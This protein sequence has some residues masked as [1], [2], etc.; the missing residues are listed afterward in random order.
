MLDRRY[1]LTDVLRFKNYAYA[2]LPLFIGWL[3]V[4]VFPVILNE[5]RAYHQRLFS[6]PGEVPG[7]EY[8]VLWVWIATLLNQLLVPEPLRLVTIVA[9][10]AMVFCLLSRNSALFVFLTLISPGIL[11]FYCYYSRQAFSVS[12]LLFFLFLADAFKTTR[13]LRWASVLSLAIHAVN[14]TVMMLMVGWPLLKDRKKKAID[15]ISIGGLLLSLVLAVA[16]KRYISYVSVSAS[17]LKLEEM[18]FA[19][20]LGL[21]GFMF[22]ARVKGNPIS[23]FDYYAV[24]IGLCFALIMSILTPNGVRLSY[25]LALLGMYFVRARPVKWAVLLFLYVVPLLQGK[26]TLDMLLKTTLG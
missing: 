12:W 23:R 11:E 8:R 9:V 25:H 2:Y 10:V 20:L 7:Y 13:W 17:T 24:S 18:V 14:V 4:V 15:A 1:R 3:Y 6:T 16:L 19:L 5:D 22:F 26:D 21:L